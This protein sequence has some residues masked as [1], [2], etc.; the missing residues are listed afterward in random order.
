MGQQA[1]LAQ[2]TADAALAQHPV[3]DGIAQAA[4]I[5]AGLVDGSALAV[6]VF[7]DGGGVFVVA[8]G[9]DGQRLGAFQ[10][11][12]LAVVHQFMLPAIQRSV[13]TLGGVEGVDLLGEDAKHLPQAGTGQA[14]QVAQIVFVYGAQHVSAVQGAAAGHIS[15][16]IGSCLAVHQV[17]HGRY[18][19]FVA[20][21]V[22]G[23]GNDVAIDAPL[24]ELAVVGIAGF[25]I[26]FVCLGIALAIVQGPHVVP[27]ENNGGLGRSH[28]A[29]YLV[30][31][32]QDLAGSLDAAEDTGM[33]GAVVTHHCA[34]ELFRGA[35][36]LAPLE[37]LDAV[38]AVGHRL[39]GGQHVQAGT[40]GLVVGLPVD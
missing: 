24:P 5:P 28:G 21:K 16:Q 8:V 4:N 35:A 7:G 36:A 27:V 3:K 12:D 30:D 37:V 32:L 11:D 33:L 38:A 22:S 34:V 13:L 26:L 1:L 39:Q 10:V 17:Q 25:K 14:A 15:G 23:G 20:G 9:I 18:H 29:G 19:D 6:A 40:L 2:C 31:G